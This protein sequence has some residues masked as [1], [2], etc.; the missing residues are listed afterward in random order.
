MASTPALTSQS[1]STFPNCQW[2]CCL[3]KAKTL[4]KPKTDGPF[5]GSYERRVETPSAWRLGH[6]H[7]GETR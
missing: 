6:W 2:S 5:A 3:G 4:D 7:H 1:Y